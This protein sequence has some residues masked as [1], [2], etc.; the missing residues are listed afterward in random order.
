MPE[1]EACLVDGMV[2]LSNLF[3]EQPKIEQ[4]CSL[5]AAEAMQGKI[6]VVGDAGPDLAELLYN[7]V[8][9]FSGLRRVPRNMW[10]VL[11]IPFK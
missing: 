8:N 1:T 6:T 2:D 11:Q 9:H 3:F 10:R 7:W 4:M 5:E